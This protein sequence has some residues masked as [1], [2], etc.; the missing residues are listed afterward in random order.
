MFFTGKIP[1]SINT[2]GLGSDIALLHINSCSCCSCSNYIIIFYFFLS[3]AP[4]MVWCCFQLVAED[5]IVVIEYPVELKTL[6]HVL[7]NNQLFG[8]RN[9]RFGR[10]VLGTYV[11][12]PSRSYDMRPDEFIHI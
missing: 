8:L 3:L 6:P 7:G 12:R 5:T 1:Q 11:C 2:V 10:T 4:D 9:R